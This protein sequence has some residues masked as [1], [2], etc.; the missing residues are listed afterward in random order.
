MQWSPDAKSEPRMNL[1]KSLRD[2]E[3]RVVPLR[4]LNRFLLLTA[5]GN[6][7]TDSKQKEEMA[8]FSR[9]VT[10]AAATGD[11]IQLTFL[12]YSKHLVTP[13]PIC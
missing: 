8:S 1:A 13:R 4:Q 5:T 3:R 12:L 11:M 9:G 2:L 6:V 7:S 10:T